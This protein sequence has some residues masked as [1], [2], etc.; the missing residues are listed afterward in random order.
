VSSSALGSP[1]AAMAAEGAFVMLDAE[2]RAQF[3]YESGHHHYRG[4]PVEI[5]KTYQ[6]D[7]VKA[8]QYYDRLQRIVDTYASPEW[9]AAA[10]A[11]QGSLYDALRTGLYDVRP[12]ALVMFDKKTE[13]LLKTAEESDNMDLQEKADA[14]RMSVET[15]WRDKRDQELDSADRIM[16]DRYANAVVIARRYNVSNPTIVRAIQRLAFFTEVIGEAKLAGYTTS[17]R[18]LSYSEGLFLRSRPGLVEAPPPSGAAPP[19]PAALAP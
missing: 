18:D 5:V 19:A 12:P 17:V 10:V 15:A 14:V 1:E 2:L 13:R 11:R 9:A 3:D 4:T 16:I 6:N 8:K 7:A